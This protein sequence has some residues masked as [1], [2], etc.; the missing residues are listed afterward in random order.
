MNPNVVRRQKYDEIK[1]RLSK[2]EHDEFMSAIDK[3]FKLIEESDKNPKQN[4][5]NYYLTLQDHIEIYDL[6]LLEL[7]RRKNQAIIDYREFL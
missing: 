4:D 3:I 2:M 6:M 7:S 1:R 5:L